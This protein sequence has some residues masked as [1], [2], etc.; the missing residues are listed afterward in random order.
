M[1]GLCCL[2]TLRL[3]LGTSLSPEV[4]ADFLR[5]WVILFSIGVMFVIAR[6]GIQAYRA[7][8]G[9]PLQFLANGRAARD[10]A[11]IVL[12]IEEMVGICDRMSMPNLTWQ[13]PFIQ[14]ALILLLIS[15]HYIDRRTYREVNVGRFVEQIESGYDTTR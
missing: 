10:V 5:I 12:I 1:S 9:G 4:P 14:A 13:T 7:M 6:S 8:H 3:M 2:S 15:W 11:I